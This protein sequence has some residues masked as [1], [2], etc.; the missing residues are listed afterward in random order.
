MRRQ[1]LE[2]LAG[3]P[4]GPLHRLIGIGIGAKRNDL[5]SVAGRAQLL[6]E[7]PGGVR[8]EE[9]LGLEVEARRE[10]EIGM[11][12]PREAID[13]AMLAAAI[14]VDGAVEGDVGRAVAGNHLPRRIGRERGP[15]RRQ[16]F[17]GSA[18]APAVVE[19]LD[20][21][22]FEPSGGV[23]HGTAPLARRQTGGL[24]GHAT[25]S[26]DGRGGAAP[27]TGSAPDRP[28]RMRAMLRR[29]LGVAAIRMTVPVYRSSPL[30]ALAAAPF[31]I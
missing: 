23:R 31:M 8:L 24:S 26:P 1:D 7:K 2:N 11:G 13:A 14:G 30:P 15:E 28:V 19:R 9:Q 6:R 12:R 22:L 4:P 27:A 20:A 10:P 5:A 17:S 21:G 25:A 3:D 18:V 29:R 16:G